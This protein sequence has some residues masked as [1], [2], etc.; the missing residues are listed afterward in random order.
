MYRNILFTL[1]ATFS[2]INAAQAWGCDC[3]SGCNLENCYNDPQEV[4][5]CH[6]NC[7]SFKKK[8]GLY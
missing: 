7:V 2:L 3:M 6:D 8:Y 4:K 1:I 5:W